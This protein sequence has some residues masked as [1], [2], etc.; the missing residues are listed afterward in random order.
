MTLQMF[1]RKLDLFNLIY[2]KEMFF[3][4]GGGNNLVISIF[5]QSFWALISSVLIIAFDLSSV[6]ISTP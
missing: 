6:S 3:F 2:D 5:V 4:L 1:N